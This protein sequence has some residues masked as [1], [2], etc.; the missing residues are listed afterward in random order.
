MILVQLSLEVAMLAIKYSSTTSSKVWMCEH[1]KIPAQSEKALLVK[2]LTLN[3]V[4]EGNFE[5]HFL[6]NSSGIYATRNH[7]I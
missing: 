5:P 3:F 2:C 6:P 7:V 4:L 1:A